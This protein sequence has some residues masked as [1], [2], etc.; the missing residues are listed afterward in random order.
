MAI[1][2]SNR[3]AIQ[4]QI[5]VD[6]A[7][8]AD[9]ADLATTAI[10]ASY[11]LTASYAMNGGGGGG[12]TTGSFTG[13]FTGSLLGTS[14][15]AITASYAMNGGGSIDTSS[16]ATTGSNIFI[17]NQTISGSLHQSGTFYPDI[18]DW[19][20]SSITISTGS[21][22]LTTDNNGVTHYDSYINIADALSPYISINTSSFVTTSSFNAFTSSIQGQVT[23]LTN[24]TSSYVLNSQTSSFVTNSQTSSFVQN[25]QTSS[26]VTTSSFNSFTGSY[27]TGSF[28]G[29]FTG[30]LLGTSSVSLTTDKINVID[31][32]SLAAEFYPVIV[33]D[34]GNMIPYLDASFNYNPSTNQL[35]VGGITS[36]LF[37]TSSWAVSSSRSITSSYITGSTFTSTNPALSASYSLTSS[38]ALNGTPGGVSTTIQ[39]NSGGFFGGSN[40]LTYQ[41]NTAADDAYRVN[42]TSNINFASNRFQADQ[43]KASIVIYND[44]S[45]IKQ[46]AGITNFTTTQ[47]SNTGATTIFIFEA[48][49]GSGGGATLKVLGFK[50][51]YSLALKDGSGFYSATRIGTLQG[52]WDFDNTITPIIQDNFIS[53]DTTYGELG[54]AVFSLQWNGTD[55][56]LQLDTTSVNYETYFNGLFNIFSQTDV[57]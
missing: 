27:T 44:P 30:S 35:S 31:G 50:C 7:T 6:N 10:S 34:V 16:L 5:K 43:Y 56:E 26:F 23:S 24:A 14:S 9:I 51:D 19:I 52:V 54:T 29:S 13:S 21:Y 42:H 25:S 33:D 37:G 46:F 39:F 8:H 18:I 53:G 36:S 1:P 38:Y 45:T 55:V 2:S 48:G 32:S 47:V 17:G 20:N 41:Y 4:T 22:I 57:T 12:T 40:N 11:T 28:T 49:G 3:H 15:Y